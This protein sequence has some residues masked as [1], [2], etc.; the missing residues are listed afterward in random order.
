M[1]FPLPSLSLQFF[2]LHSLMC[3]FLWIVRYPLEAQF[4]LIRFLF[5]YGQFLHRPSLYDLV[6]SEV[7][8]ILQGFSV[9]E[10]VG[11]YP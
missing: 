7:E 8:I 11:D 2:S 10:I 5:C 6:D 9:D 1:T 3:S 4:E